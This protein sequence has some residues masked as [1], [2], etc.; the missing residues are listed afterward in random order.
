MNISDLVK[1]VRWFKLGYLD[2]GY[3]HIPPSHMKR[4]SRTAWF[5]GEDKEIDDAHSIDL[6]PASNPYPIHPILRWKAFS[7]DT[8]QPRVYIER[9]IGSHSPAAVTPVSHRRRIGSWGGEIHLPTFHRSPRTLWLP[10]KTIILP[11]WLHTRRFPGAFGGK[12]QTILSAA[13]NLSLI[14]C[15]R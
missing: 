13:I 7:F 6:T 12:R 9:A 2:I 14:A 11:P 5:Y 15:W 8:R 3:G 10:R 1:F 4:T